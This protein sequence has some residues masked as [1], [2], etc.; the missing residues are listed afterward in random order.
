MPFWSFYG[1]PKGGGL[2]SPLPHG[3][4]NKTARTRG[5]DASMKRYESPCLAEVKVGTEDVMLFSGELILGGK[6]PFKKDID[7]DLLKKD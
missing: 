5:K 7:W 4:K 3:D 6:D 2:F 1:G